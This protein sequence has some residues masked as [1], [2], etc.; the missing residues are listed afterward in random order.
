[1][2]IFE[3]RNMAAS[4]KIVAFMVSL[5][6]LISTAHSESGTASYSQPLGGGPPPS[7]YGIF[8]QTTLFAAASPAIWGRNGACGKRYRITCTGSSNPGTPNPCTGR[9]VDVQIDDFCPACETTFDLNQNAFAVIANLDAGRI[10]IQYNQ[11]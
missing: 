5:M 11:L 2:F 4:M 3:F 10:T 8:N 7:C 9:S 6:V 1:M